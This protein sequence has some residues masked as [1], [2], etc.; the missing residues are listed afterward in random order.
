M[1]TKGTY[2][3]GFDHMIGDTVSVLADGVIHDDV[4]VDEYGG[5]TLDREAEEV[6]VGYPYIPKVE[7]MPLEAGG[8]D[9]GSSRG[10]IKRIHRVQFELYKTGKCQS[11]IDADAVDDVELDSSLYSGSARMDFSASPD[12]QGKVYITTDKPLPLTI[13]SVT[14]KGVTYAQ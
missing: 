2:F 7:P 14:M 6:I 12:E 11:G 10:D 9:G 5:I 4:V 1:A 13:L 3:I 8:E